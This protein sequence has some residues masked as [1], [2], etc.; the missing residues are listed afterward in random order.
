MVEMYYFERLS[1]T[2]DEAR[3]FIM[4]ESPQ[5]TVMIV[6]K[7][8]TNGYGRFKRPFYSPQHGL[9]LTFIVPA[10][11]ITCTLPLVTHATAVAAIE[12]IGQLSTQDV[13]I[14]WVN[15]LYVA[16]RK[17][18]GIL[19]EQMHT[20]DQ[21]YLLIGIGINIRPQDIPVALCDKMATLDYHGPELPAGWLE[22]LGDGI[23]HTLQSSDAWIMTQYREH[24]MVIGAQV[25][26]QVGHE[27]I[28]GQ[29]VAI[30]D[31]GGLVIQTH[32]EQ[33]TIYTGE[34][35]RLVLTGGVG[36]DDN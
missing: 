23:M 11:M 5:D 8:Q 33:R 12:R 2:Q 24:S 13:K 16:D 32:D 3:Q 22:Q 7:E 14:K 26:A 36:G 6:A 15:D 18:G 25:S 19:T 10:Q 17:V 9:Y 21:D 20:P 31:Q 30:T 4:R 29:A 1:S 28:N 27:T 35:T 34:L